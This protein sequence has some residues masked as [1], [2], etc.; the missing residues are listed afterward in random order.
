M[1]SSS[2]DWRN[3]PALISPF[4]SLAPDLL[5]DQCAMHTMVFFE[6][7]EQCPICAAIE[8]KRSAS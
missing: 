6:P 3:D 8:E 1:T 7:G 2:G 5:L 4:V